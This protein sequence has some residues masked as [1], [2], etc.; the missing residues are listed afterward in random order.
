MSSQPAWH[1]VANLG[2]V[3]PLEHGGQFVMIDRRGVYDP[4]LWIF[5]ENLPDRFYCV[6]LTRCHKIDDDAVGDNMYHPR[7]H[8]WF[9]DKRALISVS[10]SC[11]IPV[12]KLIEQLCDSKPIIR[13][14]AY[15]S[16]VFI[17]GRQNFDHDP[18]QFTFK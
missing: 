17:H 6:T 9:G 13:A 8:A 14:H 7:S 18:S 1:C 15:M 10:E 12:W 16:L 4:E 5:D 3:N 2:D 11:D